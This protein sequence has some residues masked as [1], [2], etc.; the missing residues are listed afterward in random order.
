LEIANPAGPCTLAGGEGTTSDDGKLTIQL[1]R[2]V[3]GTWSASN[4]KAFFTPRQACGSLYVPSDG[5]DPEK[6]QFTVQCVDKE[7]INFDWLFVK[8]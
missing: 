5:F 3:K 4:A 7:R 8:I 6:N 2:D 1:P